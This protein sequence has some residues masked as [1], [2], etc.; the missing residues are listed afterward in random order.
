[1]ENFFKVPINFDNNKNQLINSVNSD[2]LIAEVEFKDM[3]CSLNF[4]KEELVLVDPIFLALQLVANIKSFPILKHMNYELCPLLYDD[5]TLDNFKGTPLHHFIKNYFEDIQ[6]KVK[7]SVKNVENFD[8]L[9]KIFMLYYSILI[10]KGLILNL[11]SKPTL[12]LFPILNKFKYTYDKNLI[13]CKL[14]INDNK[15]KII[16]TK[17]ISP[18]SNLYIPYNLSSSFEFNFMKYGILPDSFS[19]TT[20]TLNFKDYNLTLATNMK[21]D[22][23]I[24]LRRIRK[25]PKYADLKKELQTLFKKNIKELEN[26]DTENKVIREYIKTLQR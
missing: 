24:M 20:I 5:K 26:N 21:N 15:L 4:S 16:S 11:N 19:N 10:T 14:E 7:K 3:I 22:D 23:K 9:F 25:N 12:C 13:N 18:N 8:S 1:M 6:N 17:D 2:S